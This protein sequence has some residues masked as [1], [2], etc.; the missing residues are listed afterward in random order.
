MLAVTSDAA[1]NCKLDRKTALKDRNNILSLDCAAHLVA[2][3]TGAFFKVGE[4]M[5]FNMNM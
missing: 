4:T 3:I 2:L 1:A 5:H